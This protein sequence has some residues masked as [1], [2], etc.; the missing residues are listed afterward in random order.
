MIRARS[1]TRNGARFAS[2]PAGTR[3]GSRA[4][5][6]A[7][8]L[9]A[10]A[11]AADALAADAL[12]T[13]ALA[14]DV[15]AGSPR[16]KA[17][18]RLIHSAESTMRARAPRAAPGGSAAPAATSRVRS[19]ASRPASSRPASIGVPCRRGGPKRCQPVGDR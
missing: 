8:S 10:D 16:R 13:D 17:T 5:R 12:A 2:S 1:A 19:A 9:A 3:A 7:G 4:D 15:A 11:L 14:A 6:S 18:I